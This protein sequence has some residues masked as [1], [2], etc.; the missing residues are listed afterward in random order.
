TSAE[1]RQRAFGDPDTV[2]VGDFHLA[3]T[4]CWALEGDLRGRGDDA[5]MLELLEPYRGHR[6]RVQRLL[7]LAGVNA[8]R[9]GPRYSPPAHRPG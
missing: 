4:I 9:R 3:R 2:S 1:V 7:E 5:R 8:P 6:Y